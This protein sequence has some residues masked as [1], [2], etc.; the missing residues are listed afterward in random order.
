VKVYQ[1]LGVPNF[2]ESWSLIQDVAADTE[3]RSAAFAAGATLRIDADAADVLYASG[4]TAVITE[5]IGRRAQP[6]PGVLDLT[7]TLTAAMISAGIVTSA[8]A[9]VTATLDTGTVMDAALDMVV[10]ES[11][12]WAAIKVGANAFT[13]T[14]SAGHTLEGSGVVATATSGYFR[15]RKTA[16]NTFVTSRL[17]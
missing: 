9:A 6:A 4:V 13:V 17:G 12:D 1:L 10:D 16:V 11:F 2:P 14:A 7:A 3:Y 8:A 15:T 5:N